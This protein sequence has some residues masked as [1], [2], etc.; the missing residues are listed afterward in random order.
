MCGIVGVFNYAGKESHVSPAVLQRMTDEI[1]HRGPDDSGTYISPDRKIGFG[2]RRLSIVD[3]SMAG[4]QPMSTTDQTIWLVFNGEI[5][6]HLDIRKDLEARGYQYRSKTDTETILYAYQEYGLDFIS[7][8]YG[9][10]AIAIWDAR[11]QQLLL[12]RD[13]V[14][15]KPL[16]YTIQDGALFFGSEI[17]SL[18]RH[19]HVAR[20]LNRQGLYDY[21]T[22]LMT[23]PNETLFKGIHKLEAGHYMTMD[24][25]GNVRTERYW[26]LDH[27]TETHEAGSFADENFCIDN[28]R[29]LLR[30]SIKLRMMS[31]VPFGVFLSGGIDSSLNVALMSELTSRPVE[32]FSVGY[33]D[34]EKYNE[35]GYARQVSQQFKTNHH[36]IFL[37]E[38]DLIDF[39]PKMVW[40]LDEPNADPVCVPMYYVSKLARDSG[41]I[42]AQVGEGS[43]EQFAG[44]LHYLREVKFHR[45]YYSLLP[46][47]ARQAG[48][49]F[50]R[51]FMP[52]SIMTDYARRARTRDAS[53]YGGAIGFTEELKGRLLTE[54]FRNDVESS[55]RIPGHYAAELQRMTGAK[56]N[57]S[58]E[59][60]LR[61]MVYYEF[62]NRLAELLLMRVDKMSMAVSIESRVPFLD[63]RLVE[64]SFRIPQ[65]LKLKDGVPKYIL[66]KAAEGIIPNE[67]IYRRKQ[68]FAAPVREWLR[69]GTLARHAYERIMESSL[70]RQNIFNEAYIK[71]LF[72]K[73]AS[74]AVNFD[75]QIWTLLVASMWYDRFFVQA[76][77]E[78]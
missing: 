58:S 13:R 34:L 4:H 68:G 73:H 36:E 35:L 2:F 14:G 30:D 23:P 53:F 32:T 61:Q 31:D 64:F 40:H 11:K 59:N 37:E 9:M 56:G 6:N 22:F 77:Q 12:V 70:L 26:N 29:R 24:R 19:P 71:S 18:L 39:L 10:F 25:H 63:H 52:D 20:D 75:G 21:L 62:K 3:L 78:S 38:K 1:H 43:D 15:V 74:G 76:A 48:Y 17:K 8:L 28:I 57:S 65:A 16:Y 66:K 67:I 46:G 55:G 72:E 50:F 60:F 69:T 27:Q 47:I 7:K 45:Y 42:V 33:K 41:T 54:T 44:Y 5:Y 51:R 49:A